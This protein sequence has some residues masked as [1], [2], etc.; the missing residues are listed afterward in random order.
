MRK[1]LFSALI[2]LMVLL[3]TNANAQVSFGVKGGLNVSSMKLKSEV[4]EPSNKAGFFIGPTA[5]FTLPVVG[6]GIDASLLYDQRESKVKGSN[7]TISTTLVQRQVVLPI[8]LRYSTGLGSFA[9]VFAFAGPQFGFNVDDKSKNIIQNV[10]DWKFNNSNF[11]INF[12]VG[13]TL[14]KH[15]QLTANYNVACGKTGEMT[16]L[17]GAH[18]VV[19]GRN[20]SWQLGAAFFF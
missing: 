20:S 14:L 16:I 1:F 19:E 17:Q 15:L 4:A 8:N 13:T 18:S 3:S 12:G 5:K 7:S 6:L 9:S 11:S 10:A 2:A